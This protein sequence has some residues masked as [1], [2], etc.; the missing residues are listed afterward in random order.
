MPRFLASRDP[1]A[2]REAL[3][4]RGM[5]P[6][7]AESI[8]DGFRTVTI[9]LDAVDD[10][11]KQV[12][13]QAALL[14]GLELATGD[15]WLTI[16]GAVTRLAGLARSTPD[17]L[18]ESLAMDLGTCLSRAA[19]PQRIWKMSM[20]TVEVD[21][22]LVMGILNVTPDSFSDGGNYLA[23]DSAITRAD[24]LIEIG[25]DMIDVGGE[26][27]RP[28]RPDEVATDE[29]WQ[30]I[31]PVVEHMRGCHPTVPLSVD[32]VKSEIAE[33]A[34]GTGAWAVNDV[35]AL[36]LD[37]LIADVCSRNGAGLIL[38]HSRGSFPEM[39][40][41]EHATYSDVTTEIAHELMAAL[42][43]AEDRGVSLEQIV[44]DP[45]LGF[46]KTP[47]QNCEVFRGLPILASLGLP[48]LVGPSRKRFLGEIT[49]KDTHERD[50]ATA[51]ACVAAFFGG[52]YLFR[53]HDV[54]GVKES[55]AVAEALRNT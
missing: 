53:V 55:L 21:R 37:P 18:P 46:A 17:V 14:H 44:I 54:S 32:T 22:P 28:G 27:T 26:S 9:I 12:L 50:T 3:V 42:A 7:R 19:E 2:I 52:A 33:R 47:E 20:G 49:G 51:A 16:S 10:D 40:G 35:S 6:A 34:L 39:A 31:R 13:S 1:G 38:S 24:Q 41:Y 5:E 8:V 30:R 36:R 29:E 23:P 11:S 4:R 15:G 48:V 43:V 45:G 25:A